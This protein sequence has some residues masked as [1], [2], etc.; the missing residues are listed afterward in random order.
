MWWFPGDF[1]PF[2][3]LNFGTLWDLFKAPGRQ[4][5]DSMMLKRFLRS[6]SIRFLKASFL[7][8][9]FLPFNIG[10]FFVVCVCVF[11]VYNI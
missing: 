7:R 5:H 3:A 6:V 8:A 10:C 4:I 1:W 2:W 9:M 11:F